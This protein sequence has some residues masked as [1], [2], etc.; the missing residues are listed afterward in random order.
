M[1]KFSSMSLLLLS[2]VCF[3]MEFAPFEK[4]TNLPMNE[5][6]VTGWHK[7]LLYR[8]KVGL[9]GN[10]MEMGYPYD[11]CMWTG[12]IDKTQRIVRQ[13]GADWFPYE[14]TAYYLDGSLRTS[15]LLKDKSLRKL[16][17]KN[18]D[19]IIN[20]IRKD[21]TLGP[22]NVANL[23]W[24]RT[25]FFRM[26]MAEY[27][28]TKNPKIIEALTTHYL[29]GRPRIW[30]GRSVTNV[31]ILCWL[32]KQTDDKRFL[33]FAEENFSK[34]A[35]STGSMGGNSLLTEK[36]MRDHGVTV[37]ELIKLPTIMYLYTGNE[38]YLEA[39]LHGIKKLYRDYG[40][41]SELYSAH[42][43]LSDKA[44]NR[45]TETCV[46][47]D[48]LWSLGYIFKATGDVKYAD[49]MEKI[50]LNAGIGA[51][52]KDFKTLQYFSGVNQVT[53]PD[54]KVHLF[55]KSG[56][57][58]R[59]TYAPQHDTEC[60]S[61]NVHRI[62]PNYI[63][64]MWMKIRKNGLA[65]VLYGP[66]A[67]TTKINNQKVTVNAET[68]YPFE[69][70]ITFTIKSSKDVK[71]PFYLRIPNWSESAE[72]LVNGEKIDVAA[73]SG[74][75]AIVDRKFRNGDK[76]TLNL[77]NKFRLIKAGLNDK[78]LAIS[79]GAL[80]YSLPIKEKVN[81]IFNW[82]RKSENFDAFEILPNSEWRYALDARDLK[83]NNLKLQNNFNK[84]SYPWEYHSQKVKVP[85]Y[86]LK[87][88]NLN[89][90]HFTPKLPTNLECSSD[91]QFVELVPLGCTRLRLTVFPVKK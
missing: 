60:C 83:V 27:E 18:I 12:K 9:T 59:A 50:F 69:D 33:D 16:A 56:N 78:G 73:H 14:Q 11:T 41:V 15:Y 36:P 46:A 4:F 49:M 17:L 10:P 21:N 62:A 84:N 79:R 7:Q 35:K 61:G 76:I 29:K 34:F 3:S 40:L 24:P 45:V 6:N 26:L 23:E 44:A 53:L 82:K 80:L 48:M 30:G 77:N 28:N 5:I 63:G 1:K 74:S 75:F 58:R 91:K 71:F 38:K 31:E 64:R 39:T 66:G 72:V 8:Q 47:A 25:V 81:K 67:V 2:S 57:S 37:A 19:F 65:A 54:T 43:F 89:K 32:Y 55:K 13:D 85:V 70:T 22:E 90:K 42:E 87:N 86:T 51:F 52:G 68:S 20:N 88:W